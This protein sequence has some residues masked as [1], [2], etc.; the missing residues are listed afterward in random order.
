MA[1]WAHA[2]VLSA[3]QRMHGLAILYCSVID[4]VI[5]WKVCAC[6]MAPGT[7]F[8]LNLRHVASNAL[9]S[10]AAVF[11]VSVRGQGRC[12]RTVRRGR[13]VAVKTDLIGGL[14]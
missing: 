8:G 11:L 2:V 7:P 13:A 5:T 9:A 12:V 3:W 14:A 1:S 6:T 10:R 4:G